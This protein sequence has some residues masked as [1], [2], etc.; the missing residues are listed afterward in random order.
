MVEFSSITI[1]NCGFLNVCVFV[2][3]RIPG[4]LFI[5]T[6]P[7][8]V[9]CSISDNLQVVF[10]MCTSINKRCLMKTNSLNIIISSIMT[11]VHDNFLVIFFYRLSQILCFFFFF[12]YFTVFLSVRLNLETIIRTYIHW[13]HKTVFIST[14]FMSFKVYSHP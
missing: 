14:P 12:F 5:G 8:N 2:N 13:H 6:N 3:Y 4:H 1:F 10:K 9:K 11:M 7:A